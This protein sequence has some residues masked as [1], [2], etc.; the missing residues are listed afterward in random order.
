MI[1]K[2][3]RCTGCSACAESCPKRCIEMREDSEGFLYPEVDTKQCISCNKCESVCPVLSDRCHEAVNYP[4]KAY[5]VINNDLD[6]RLIS[7][8]G[9]A[10]AMFA[11]SVI[12]HQ[13]VVYGA[14]FSPD[15]CAVHHVRITELSELYRLQ[16]SK[17]VQSDINQVYNEV[18]DDLRHEKKVLFSGTPCQN[19][20]LKAFLGKDYSN[21]L[22]VEFICHG[23]PSP[24][25]WRKYIK[26][27][28][29]KIGGRLTKVEFRNKKNL[30]G[31]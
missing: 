3:D 31:Y 20:G 9:G 2:N 15:F 5:A 7:S 19:A 24:K 12:A 26:W 21:L 22:C 16:G 18:L 10:F 11:E 1:A 28:K 8:S 29:L 13:G 30:G 4:K 17:Y 27:V 23:V 25:L 6:R 14:A